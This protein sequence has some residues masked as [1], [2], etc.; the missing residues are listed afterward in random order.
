MRLQHT[1]HERLRGMS[2]L[3]TPKKVSTPP[4]TIL[5]AL[6]TAL[7]LLLTSQHSFADAGQQPANSVCPCAISGNPRAKLI[8]QANN[9]PTSLPQNT[10]NVPNA[11]PPP[12]APATLPG[13]GPK[14]TQD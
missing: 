4:Q 1:S 3:F 14:P 6:L 11:T 8:A 12:E 5:N 10:N 2:V 7:C 13:S 9:V